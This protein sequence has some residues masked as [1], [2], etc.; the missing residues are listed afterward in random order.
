MRGVTLRQ[1]RAFSLVSRHHSFALAAAELHLTPSAVSLQIK[2]LEQAAGTPLLGRMPKGS[3]LTPAGE[4]LLADVHVALAALQHADEALRRLKQRMAGVVSVG[5]VSSA[6]YFLPRLLARFR[7]EHEGVE[8][9]LTVA[10][11]DRLLDL[12]RRG[13]ID[14]AVMGAPPDDFDGTAEA[15]ATLPMGV[16]ASP[17]H[18]LAQA[19]SIPVEKLSSLDFIVREP[20]SGTRAAMERFFFDR[21]LE[22]PPL[23]EV[24][25]N[26]ALKQAVMANL[27]L[28]FLSMHAAALELQSQ[29]LVALDVV[30]LPLMRRWFVVHRQPVEPGA[31]EVALGRYIL[32]RGAVL[33]AGPFDTLATAA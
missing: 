3:W 28:A 22:L 14:V 19:R 1:L 20:G 15:F 27:G 11:R 16:L 32:D 21:R 5:M 23:T 25:G 29:L 13:E 10:N 6:K 31:A 26:S 8:L 17:E 18:D 30:G 4:L 9:R 2:E 24:L 33:F 7:A 12:L